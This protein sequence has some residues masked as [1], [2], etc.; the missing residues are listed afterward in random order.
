MSEFGY[1]VPPSVPP[2]SLG[3]RILRGDPALHRQKSKDH[4]QK[5]DPEIGDLYYDFENRQLWAWRVEDNGQIGH[6]QLVPLAGDPLRFRTPP[7]HV[8]VGVDSGTITIE[9]RSGTD[10]TLLTKGDLKVY[11]YTN[12]VDVGALHETFES[13]AVQDALGPPQVNHITIVDGQ[14]SANFKYKTKNAVVGDIIL[15]TA[16]VNNLAPPTP[17]VDVPVPEVLAY[18]Y[19]FV[20]EPVLVFTTPPFQVIVANV[21]PTITV[22]RQDAKGT[23]LTSGDQLVYLYT[24]SPTGSFST[25]LTATILDGQSTVSFTYVESL[26]P[27]NPVLTASTVAL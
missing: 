2:D 24:T 27:G 7:F 15:I 13:A 26:T 25:G 18:T 17:A 16:S 1:N 19:L 20:D 22:Q 23:P 21:S 12:V 14:S 9:R 3:D 10:G 4:K 11:L 8:S 6:W 5:Y